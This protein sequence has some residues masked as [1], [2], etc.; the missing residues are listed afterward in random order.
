MNVRECSY[1]DVGVESGGTTKMFPTDESTKA[2]IKNSKIKFY[3]LDLDD[4]FDL[5]GNF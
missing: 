3:C 1:Q 4:D 5:F 2:M